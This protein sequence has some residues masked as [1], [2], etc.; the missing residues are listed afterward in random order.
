MACTTEY[1]FFQISSPFQQVNVENS[2]RVGH[3]GQPTSRRLSG[4]HP[5]ASCMIH[6]R[7]GLSVT[8][9]GA[10]VTISNCDQRSRQK[11][12]TSNSF[13][14]LRMWTLFQF[15]STR[16]FFTLQSG[17]ML[18][19]RLK[20]AGKIQSSFISFIQPHSLAP[21]FLRSA[22]QRGTRSARLV[23]YSSKF[24]PLPP[25]PPSELPSSCC[26]RR[27]LNSDI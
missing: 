2:S 1:G 8:E 13:I 12:K 7:S 22:R 26:R 24:D 19:E 10:G 11:N 4:S 21:E 18:F 6:F 15:D 3:D 17:H 23:H 16:H 20:P 25:S 14:L 5:A 9:Q 27:F